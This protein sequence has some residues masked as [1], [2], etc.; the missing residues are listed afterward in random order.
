MTPTQA[1]FIPQ[2]HEVFADFDRSYKVMMKAISG[3][4]EEQD[5]VDRMVDVIV[6]GQ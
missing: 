4:D 6:G 5:Q 3:M 2:D 1:F